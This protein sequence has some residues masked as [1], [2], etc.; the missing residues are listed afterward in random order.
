MP[1]IIGGAALLGAGASLFGSSSAADAQA[2]A[3]ANALKEQKREF[4]YQTGTFKPYLDTGNKANSALA[5]LY[6]LN[7]AGA[8]QSA[9]DMYQASPGFDAALQGGLG[10]VTKRFAAGPSGYGGGGIQK[11]LLDY[12]Q[13][14]RLGDFYQWRQGLAQQQGVG[15]DA[16]A[17]T[18]QAAQNYGNQASS[19]YQDQGASTAGAYLAGANGVNGAISN[20][21][22]LYGYLNRPQQPPA[23]STSWGGV[24][25]A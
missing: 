8:A 6:G 10:D 23:S 12:G 1:W 17:R 4:D 3:A 19:L 13:R 14:A 7:G 21:L 15:L 20:G 25:Y 18:G 11:A 22:Q 16:A 2:K 9:Y 24:P 5:D